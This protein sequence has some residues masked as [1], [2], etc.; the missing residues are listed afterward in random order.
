MID[1]RKT[2]DGRMQLARAPSIKVSGPLYC[3]SDDCS[4]KE[5]TGSQC[6]RTCSA[7]DGRDCSKSLSV[8]RPP[9]AASS[10]ASHSTST[11]ANHHLLHEGTAVSPTSYDFDFAD[12]GRGHGPSAYS[13]TARPRAHTRALSASFR[14]RRARRCRLGH[15]DAGGQ[16]LQLQR[17]PSWLGADC[18]RLSAWFAHLAWNTSDLLLAGTVGGMLRDSVCTASTL[19]SS[20]SS[21][22]RSN[23]SKSNGT[24]D[25]GGSKTAVRYLLDCDAAPDRSAQEIWL[26]RARLPGSPTSAIDNSALSMPSIS[27]IDERGIR[28]YGSSWA[29]G[30]VE[31]EDHLRGPPRA[32]PRNSDAPGSSLLNLGYGAPLPQ[33]YAPPSATPSP[34][35]FLTRVPANFSASPADVSHPT[36]STYTVTG[37]LLVQT[38]RL[39]GPYEATLTVFPPDAVAWVVDDLNCVFFVHNDCKSKTKDG[40]QLDDAKAAETARAPTVGA[41]RGMLREVVEI[42]KGVSGAVRATRSAV[43]DCAPAREASTGA[44]HARRTH[45]CRV[46]AQGVCGGPRDE[47]VPEGHGQEGLGVFSLTA[48]GGQ[49]IVLLHR[50]ETYTFPGLV[51]LFKDMSGLSVRLADAPSRVR[52][53][54][55]RK[56]IT[57]IVSTAEAMDVDLAMMDPPVQQ[58]RVHINQ[59]LSKSIEDTIIRPGAS[60]VSI[61][62]T[63]YKLFRGGLT[64]QH[65]PTAYIL[66]KLI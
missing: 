12:D 34:P 38:E 39:C 37:H 17:S 60:P 22:S 27:R 32:A 30:V 25:A 46:R 19:A 66:G 56:G 3:P 42:V 58:Q 16:T 24:G 33:I 55:A 23:N 28:P 54:R 11:S 26:M 5:D 36:S 48:A 2:R 10:S 4:L 63:E 64:R 21:T 31:A 49:K 20:S 1:S 52:R 9:S 15:G 59:R 65:T 61:A 13:A 62:Q 40:L 53:P 50:P 14:C 18:S 7:V 6:S 29:P 47:R 57:A 44:R 35:Q 45:A 51:S 43:W 41:P 8:D